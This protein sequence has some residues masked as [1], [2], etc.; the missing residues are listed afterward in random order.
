MEARPYGYIYKITIN[1]KNSRLNNCYYIGQHKYTHIVTYWGSGVLIMDYI[2]KHGIKNLTKEILCECPDKDTLDKKEIEYINDLYLTDSISNGGKCL[3]LKAG[4]NTVG[5][6]EETREKYR[7]TSTGKHH[8]EETKKKISKLKKGKPCLK[9]RGRH[10]S[11]EHKKKIADSQKGKIIDPNVIKKIRLKKLGY[12]HSKEVKLKISI[13]G[14]GRKHSEEA[15][16]KIGKASHG[17]KWWNN[18]VEQSLCKEC[19]GKEW[20]PGIL[21]RKAYEMKPYNNGKITV[22]AKKRPK[23][24]TYGALIK[25]E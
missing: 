17:R 10:L 8:S 5:I 6:S 25:G 18:G 14:K 23:G 13:A 2:A 4:G 19:P 15:K 1:D 11:E 3:N 20:K 22:Y 12:K 7:I 24:F 9:L 21:Y 16:I